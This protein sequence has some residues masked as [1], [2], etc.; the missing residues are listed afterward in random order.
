MVLNVIL[1]LKC[2]G[3]GDQTIA[4]VDPPPQK[5]K[6]FRLPLCAFENGIALKGYPDE[7]AE[8]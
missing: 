8:I 5:K 2:E 7:K 1:N 6:K 4:V 3:R